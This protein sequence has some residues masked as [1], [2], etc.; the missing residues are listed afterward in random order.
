MVH[1]KSYSYKFNE[2]I[3]FDKWKTTVL[4]TIKAF[5]PEEPGSV[6][7]AGPASNKAEEEEPELW[8][9]GGHIV[10]EFIEFIQA[11]RNE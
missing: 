3:P 11:H 1:F 2:I 5:I 10:S 8:V 6:P 9:I 7:A 4:T